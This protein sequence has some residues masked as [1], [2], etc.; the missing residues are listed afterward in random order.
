MP[1][2]RHEAAAAGDWRDRARH[3]LLVGLCLAFAVVLALLGLS[4]GNTRFALAAPA[5]LVVY[6]AVLV[7]ANRYGP[8]ARLLSGRAVGAEEIDVVTRA[9]A[10]SWNAGLLACLVGLGFGLGAGWEPGL[11]FAVPGGVLLVSWMGALFWFH[12]RSRPPT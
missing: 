5:I 10:L 7:L 2:K 8:G 11:W 12:R 3:R 1:F 6:A 4:R 9:R